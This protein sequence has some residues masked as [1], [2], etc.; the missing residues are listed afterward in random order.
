MPP[1]RPAAGEKIAVTA[2]KAGIHELECRIIFSK[3]RKKTISYTVRY[4]DAELKKIETDSENGEFNSP[5]NFKNPVLFVRAPSGLPIRDILSVLSKNEQNIIDLLEKAIQKEEA[6]Q[7]KSRQT[8]VNGSIF[9]YMGRIYV[10]CLFYEAA[11]KIQVRLLDGQLK[12]FLPEKMIDLPAEK[13][14]QKIK[15]AIEDFYMEQADVFFNSR[16]DYFAEKYLPL[17]KE[18]PKSV[19]AVHY[20]GKWG[21]CTYQ[22]D[23]KLNWVLIQA[24][25]PVIDYVII[26][27]LCHIRH[28][29]HSKH[30]WDLV[31]AIDPN[32]IEKKGELKENGWILGLKS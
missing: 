12:V 21:C 10:L 6:F 24:E 29:N 28:K 7:K 13:K 20:K 9:H 19:K 16:A 26:H 11:A 14:E 18:K 30:F 22:N 8:Y 5:K 2:F 1:V 31:E 25:T 4:E 32:Y 15:K 3:K 17:L 27:E 23:I